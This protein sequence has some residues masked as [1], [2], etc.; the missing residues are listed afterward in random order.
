[1]LHRPVQFAESVSAPQTAA[2]TTYEHNRITRTRSRC[3]HL[4]PHIACRVRVTHPY[5]RNAS[6]MGENVPYERYDH[7]EYEK[8][9]DTIGLRLLRLANVI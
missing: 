7:L 3:S 1:M 8:H 4:L 9:V 2:A 6:F 5:V